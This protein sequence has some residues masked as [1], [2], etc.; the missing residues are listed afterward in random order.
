MWPVTCSAFSVFIVSSQESILIQEMET[1]IIQICHGFSIRKQ[2]TDR[3]IKLQ[4]KPAKDGLVLMWQVPMMIN[5][6]APTIS[7]PPQTWSFLA[8]KQDQDASWTS[9]K[10]IWPWVR[11]TSRN[12][13]IVPGKGTTREGK[14]EKEGSMGHWHPFAYD[15]LH[16]MQLCTCNS[17]GKGRNRPMEQIRLLHDQPL[18]ESNTAK[19][20]VRE[21][22]KHVKWMKCWLQ[23]KTF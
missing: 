13:Y 1:N 3:D 23:W 11:R 15:K 9:A 20:Q 12:T 14:G 10:G 8:C 17:E 6:H 21:R 22:K 18:Q 2:H 4:R 7:P 16:Q 19:C 5:S